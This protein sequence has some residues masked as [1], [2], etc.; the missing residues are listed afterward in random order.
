MKTGP[1]MVTHSRVLANKAYSDLEE[2]ACERLVLTQ[3]LMHIENPQVA[4]GVR[5]KHPKMVEAAVVATIEL[6]SY[7][8]SCSSNVQG[9]ATALASAATSNSTEPISKA[10]KQLKE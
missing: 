10:L 8:N 7:L 6:E 9:G 4:F 5:Q 1:P 3:F 2:K